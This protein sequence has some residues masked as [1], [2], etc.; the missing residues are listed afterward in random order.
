MKVK[1]DVWMVKG[2]ATNLTKEEHF[3]GELDAV[4]MP[5]GTAWI[6]LPVSCLVDKNEFNRRVGIPEIKV[7]GVFDKEL[8]CKVQLTK[9]ESVKL[10]TLKAGESMSFKRFGWGKEWVNTVE[11]EL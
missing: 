11:R 4:P 3:V 7:L 9:K 1:A 10:F 5:D 8:R 6:M 2:N